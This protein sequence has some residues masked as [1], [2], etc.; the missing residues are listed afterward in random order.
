MNV[1][2]L[3]FEK[4]PE[5]IIVK[6]SDPILIDNTSLGYHVLFY[7]QGGLLNAERSYVQGYYTFLPMKAQGSDQLLL[8]ASNRLNMYEGS[9]RHLFK[10]L[11]EGK[12]ENAGFSLTD[13]KNVS[14]N[15]SDFVAPSIPNYHKILFTDTVNILHTSKSGEV[16]NAQLI[17]HGSLQVNDGGVLLNPQNLDVRGAMKGDGVINLLPQDYEPAASGQ[18]DF[19]RYYEKIY[20]QTDKPYYYAGE[21]LWFRGYVNY[22]MAAMRDSLSAVAYVE[23]IGPSKNIILSKMYKIDSGFFHGDFILTDTL[24]AGDYYLRAYTNLGRNFTRANL[25]MKPIPLLAMTDKADPEQDKQ[26]QESSTQLTILTD[27]LKY[28]TREKINLTFQVKDAEGKPLTSNMSVSVT[29]A[30]QVVSLPDVST[31]RDGFPIEKGTSTG[32][33]EFKYLLESGIGF[34]GRFVND[35]GKPEKTTLT[36]FQLKPRNM[37]MLA[38]A[39]DQGSFSLN[40]LQFYDSADFSI[41][42]DRAKD[43]PYGKVEL[44]SRDTPII[45]F[46]K[47]DYSVA[48]VKTGTAQRLI[49]EYEVPKEN[50][51]LEA[52][53]IK[54]KRIEESAEPDYRVR[55]S[56]GSPNYV[57]KAKDINTSYGNLLMALQGKFPGLIIS[58]SGVYTARAITSSLSNAQQVLVTINDAIMGGDPGTLLSTI[59]PST[60]ESVELTTRINPLYGSAGAFG[61]LSVYTKFDFSEDNKGVEQNFQ[62]IRIAGYTTPKPFRSPDYDSPKTDRTKTDYRATIYW[63]PEVAVEGK[64]GSA[65]ISFFAADLPGRY[66]IVGEGVTQNGE[67]IRCVYF[68]EVDND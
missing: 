63:N 32:S 10:S 39:D 59:N 25:F 11:I 1:E 23:I 64:T 58:G 20:V 66:R 3:S 46:K 6:S 45:D 15:A 26:T 4:T 8:W 53:E 57:L 30:G 49:S 24:S 42:S 68:I 13:K 50:H 65:R 47:S 19:M 2:A 27:K 36:I 28:K 16:E 35:K 14:L 22:T 61:V 55:R 44:L 33:M 60:V 40:G 21:P 41:K 29:D 67:P 34:S 38:A 56:Y 5:G 7:L 31:I 17:P 43:K 51:L 18:E 54:A 52:V 62:L 48:V 12:I 9:E 37:M